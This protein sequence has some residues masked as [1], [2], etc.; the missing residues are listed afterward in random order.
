MVFKVCDRCKGT[1]I[2]TLL[3]KLKEMGKDAQIQVGCQNFCGVGRSKSFVIVDHIPI[4]AE[5]EN[6]LLE[7]LREYLTRKEK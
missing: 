7:K 2:K 4:I 3:P 6:E 1:N 5:N